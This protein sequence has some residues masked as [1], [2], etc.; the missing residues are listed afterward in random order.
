MKPALTA[1][2]IAL[3]AIALPAAPI[4]AQGQAQAKPKEDLANPGSAFAGSTGKGSWQA[5][6]TR[7]EKG[8]LIGNPKAESTMIEF[9]S[10]TCPHCA[11]F[12]NE[13]ER[14]LDLT[15]VAPGK[16]NLEVR[17]FIRNPIDLAVSLLAACG[18]L[19]GF[20]DR[21]RR[22]MTTQSEWLEKARN[23]PRSQLE[24]W[25]RGDASAR[26]NAATAL[27]LVDMFAN[28]GLSRAAINTCLT[29][30]KAAAKLLD[31][32]D[33]AR[34]EFAVPGTPSFALDGKLI[35]DV[36]DWKGLY[37]VLSARFAPP[38]TA[39]GGAAKRP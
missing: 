18:P 32:T 34:S 24:I 20:K 16:M 19:E 4:K 17:S 8:H 13:G 33:A 3:A 26:V 23:A 37:P 12:A 9:I 25:F 7:T 38:A 5:K 31:D 15:L 6:V 39:P 2:A 11:D 30:D 10:Y 21:H 29:D 22:L 35:K 14:G 27:G 28:A 1:A 36:H